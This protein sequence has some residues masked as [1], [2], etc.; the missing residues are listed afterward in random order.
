MNETIDKLSFL[1]KYHL[2]ST[3]LESGYQWEEVVDIV[4]DY[5]QREESIKEAGNE[6]FNKML[7][8]TEIAY[9]KKRTKHFE[10][11]AEKVIRKAFENKRANVKRISVNDYLERITDLIGLRLIHVF[12]ENWCELHET[13]TTIFHEFEDK[14]CV[15]LLKRDDDELYSK[16]KDSLQF[17][18]RDSGYRSV[19]YLVKQNGY[20]AE[21]QVRTIFQEGWGEVEH[22]LVYPS[23]QNDTLLR[24]YSDILN[25]VTDVA[26]TISS[27]I[28]QY[29]PVHEQRLA[30]EQSIESNIRA[31][32]ILVNDCSL[33]KE[34]KDKI[35]M[36]IKNIRTDKLDLIPFMEIV[37]EIEDN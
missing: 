25:H 9:I 22:A 10:H 28:R 5:I 27:K 18:Y 2:D 4:D 12:K 37:T 33:N 29:L 3:F 8:L 30:K 26:D 31:L 19:H 24:Q 1:E 14:P 6:L 7:S 32:S 13:L 21:I 34:V 15:N 20:I 36:V 23:R 17:C 35:E 11:L 16:Y